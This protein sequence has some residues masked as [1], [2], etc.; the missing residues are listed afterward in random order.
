MLLVLL[1]IVGGVVVAVAVAVAVAVVVVDFDH[2]LVFTGGGQLVYALASLLSNV[3][4][5]FRFVAAVA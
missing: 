5:C 3:I 1:F 4:S 2:L